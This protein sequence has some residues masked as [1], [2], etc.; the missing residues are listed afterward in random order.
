M[1]VSVGER[2]DSSRIHKC[3]GMHLPLCSEQ[4]VYRRP[5]PPIGSGSKKK[6]DTEGPASKDAPLL[7][8]GSQ[9]IERRSLNRVS[10][11]RVSVRR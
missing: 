1:I 11:T 8:T 6:W 2:D 7:V 4:V 5:P 3:P 10:I 9:K